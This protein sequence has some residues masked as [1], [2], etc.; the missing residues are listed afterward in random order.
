MEIVQVRGLLDKLNKMG[1]YWF[2]QSPTVEV[3]ESYGGPDIRLFIYN[4]TT[5]ALY[6]YLGGVYGIASFSSAGLNRNISA[7]D[8]SKPYNVI[9]AYDTVTN[10]V[11]IR[12]SVPAVIPDELE[13]KANEVLIRRIT[14]P[15]VGQTIVIPDPPEVDY[16]QAII[17]I[18]LP[19]ITPDTTPVEV[20]ATNQL[21]AILKGISD[22][23]GTFNSRLLKVDTMFWFDSL[24][25]AFLNTGNEY[26]FEV[27]G[28]IDS[29]LFATISGESGKTYEI[30]SAKINYVDS[31]NQDNDLCE[32]AI[33]RNRGG[34]YTDM[35]GGNTV[36]LD[37]GS[38]TYDLYPILSTN[39]WKDGDIVEIYVAEGTGTNNGSEIYGRLIVYLKEV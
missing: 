16:D 21:G 32:V 34:T 20:N 35:C 2:S 8:V 5:N 24:N 38:G 4:N 11:E 23:I 36:L 15:P 18:A 7:Q 33:Y 37:N 30:T 12:E 3:D 1:V 19:H 26:L 28:N 25:E 14:I 10:L 39:S 6:W 13:L 29:K 9:I 27:P 17:D 31:I 22:S